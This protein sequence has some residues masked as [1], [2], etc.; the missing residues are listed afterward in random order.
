[1]KL[2]QGQILM[3]I[4][5]NGKGF[6]INA[7]HMEDTSKVRLG[8]VGIKNVD[9]RIKLYYGEEFGVHIKSVRN[10]GTTVTM[11]LPVS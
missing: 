3:S 7:I 6:D 2:F 9:Q 1:V 8:G 4:K 10:V 5:D 11:N